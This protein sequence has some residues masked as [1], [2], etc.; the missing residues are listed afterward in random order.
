MNVQVIVVLAFAGLVLLTVVWVV[1]E[2]YLHKR[3]TGGKKFAAGG[4]WGAGGYGGY[5]AGGDSGADAGC[6]GGGGC[7]GGCGGGGS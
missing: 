4:A 2:R 3:R 1:A 7:G 6:S 5:N